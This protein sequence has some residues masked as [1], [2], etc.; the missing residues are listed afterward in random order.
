MDGIY[1]LIHMVESRC[2]IEYN[3][4]LHLESVRYEIKQFPTNSSLIKQKIIWNGK[5]AENWENGCKK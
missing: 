4:L 5:Y 2:L 1:K 3:V